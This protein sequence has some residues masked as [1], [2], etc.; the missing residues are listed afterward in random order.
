MFFNSL[1]YLASQYTK[2]KKK[3]YLTHKKDLQY[4]NIIGN[5]KQ[6]FDNIVVVNKI[7]VSI[8]KYI[9]LH[10]YDSVFN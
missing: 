7:K 2:M 5:K 6:S 4:L 10:S 1:V 9:S 8:A 3:M